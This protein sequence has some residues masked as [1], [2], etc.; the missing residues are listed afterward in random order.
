MKAFLNSVCLSSLLA[1]DCGAW[2][3]PLI[4]ELGF[5]P[6]LSLPHG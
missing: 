6:G 3:T 1:S 4:P 2:G 5:Y